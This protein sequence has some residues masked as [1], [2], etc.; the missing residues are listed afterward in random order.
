MLIVV[1]PVP[2]EV[3]SKRLGGYPVGGDWIEGDA[4]TGARA[5]SLLVCSLGNRV[6]MKLDEGFCCRD[7][8]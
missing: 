1:A 2:D 4:W 5:L 6:L 3:A 8:V 7:G